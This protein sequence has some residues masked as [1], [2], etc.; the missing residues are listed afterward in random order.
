[1]KVNV[2]DYLIA[3]VDSVDNNGNVS[4]K[5]GKKYRVDKVTYAY[6]NINGRL[7]YINGYRFDKRGIKIAFCNLKEERELKLKKIN[8]IY[9]N[10]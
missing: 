7:Y 6:S 1:M 4:L 9:E 10:I 3:K 5:K 8:L 2:G